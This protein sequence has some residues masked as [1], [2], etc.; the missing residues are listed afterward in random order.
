MIITIRL[1]K[2]I[3]VKYLEHDWYVN[4]KELVK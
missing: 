2:L 1:N 3:L 4:V